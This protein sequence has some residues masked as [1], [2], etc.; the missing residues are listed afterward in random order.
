MVDTQSP[1]ALDA[2][3][4][5]AGEGDREVRVWVAFSE[6]FLSPPAIH[7]G[8]S[9]WDMDQKTNQRADI[10]AE[11][12]TEAGFEIVFH[13]HDEVV[14]EVAE[15]DAEKAQA[16]MVELMETPPAWM[17][18]LPL[19]VMTRRSSNNPSSHGGRPAASSTA[20]MTATQSA[21][22]ARSLNRNF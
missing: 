17:A 20:M 6:P 21:S 15:G 14:C 5:W 8:L 1:G 11:N 3:E 22:M 18:R 19:G 4:M 7:V 12:I 9:M 13:V 16:R 10:S 2:L